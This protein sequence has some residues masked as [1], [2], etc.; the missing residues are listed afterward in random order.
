MPNY[1]QALH[2][3][4]LAEPLVF[5]HRWWWD[6]VP[7][8]IISALDKG[9]LRELAVVQIQTQRAMLEAQIKAT[10]QVIGILSKG[11]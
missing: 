1:P 9:V 10:D 6:P 7:D 2:P 8:W 5:R 11:R 3:E 4:A